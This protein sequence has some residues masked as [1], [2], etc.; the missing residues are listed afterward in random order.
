M[1][2][3]GTVKYPKTPSIHQTAQ[4]ISCIILVKGTS[5]YSTN[6]VA[7]K[8]CS[9]NICVESSFVQS[10]LYQNNVVLQAIFSTTTF[11]VRHVT[12]PNQNIN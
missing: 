8:D 11:L 4:T 9:Y 6:E 1:I 12:A 3:R 10:K 7:Y 2:R 5:L